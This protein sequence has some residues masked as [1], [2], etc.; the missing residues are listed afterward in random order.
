MRL[1]VLDIGSNAANLRVVDTGDGS[2]PTPFFRQKAP[3]GLADSI[4]VDGVVGAAGVR[5]LVT[6][7]ATTVDAARAQHVDELIPYVTSAV[8][9]AGNRDEI[10]AAVRAGTGIDVGFLS[11]EDEAGLTYFAVHRWYGW[12]AGA[13]SLLDI[14]GGSMEIA[15]GRD[16]DPA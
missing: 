3:T 13:L 12:S 4:G 5:R 1:G 11:G 6:A 7:V 15:Q 9:D 8:R 10:L 16:E 14:G 2:A